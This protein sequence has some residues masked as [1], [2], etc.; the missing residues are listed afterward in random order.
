[1]IWYFL[2]HFRIFY[3]NL[4]RNII[5]SLPEQI[6]HPV[7][8]IQDKIRNSLALITNFTDKNGCPI[9][10][11]IKLNE[12]RKEIL[13]NEIKSIY[14]KTNLKEY[15]IKHINENQCNIIDKEKAERL[16]RVIGL[17]LP[18]TLTAFSHDL[19]ITF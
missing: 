3:D 2:L 11:A 10:I 15:L 12:I 16:S 17:Q 7:F 1:M 5:E 19:N 4:S 6:V 14:G 9:L 8:L 13:V 18:T